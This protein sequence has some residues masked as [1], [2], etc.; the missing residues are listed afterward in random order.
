MLGSGRQ[1]F[2]VFFYIIDKCFLYRG[3]LSGHILS[4]YLQQ[5]AGIMSWYRGELLTMAKDLGY[6]LLPAFNTS[7]GLPHARVCIYSICISLL[8]VNMYFW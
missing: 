2:L 7:T 1:Y 6:R 5:R 8:N 4:E 3:L